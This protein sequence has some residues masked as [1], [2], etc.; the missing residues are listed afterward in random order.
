[1]VLV[2]LAAAIICFTGSCYPAL[3]GWSTPP[4]EYILQRRATQHPGYGGD[5]LVFKDGDHQVYAIHRL[6]NFE[7]AQE[8]PKRIKSKKPTDRIITDGCINVSPEVYQ[9]LTECCQNDILIIL[10]NKKYQF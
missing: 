9:K 7:P 6:I 8:R 4:G 1:M 5:I 2:D 3:I 10:R